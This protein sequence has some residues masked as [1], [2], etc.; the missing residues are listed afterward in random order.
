[1]CRPISLGT[2]GAI[3]LEHA[4]LGF[5]E[6]GPVS[7]YD[8]KTRCF[9]SDLAHCWTADQAQVYRTLDRMRARGLV[10]SR[11]AASKGGRGRPDRRLYTITDA[12]RAELAGW[13]SQA[14]APPPLRD[15]FLLQLFFA[16]ELPADR[17]LSLLR[18]ER[19]ARQSRLD[20]LRRRAEAV[21]SPDREDSDGER[22]PAFRKMTVAAAVAA[23]RTS[24]DWLD[25]CIE[26]VHAGIGEETG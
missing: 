18:E 14:A 24:I 21:T 15:P 23:A 4:I 12:G 6:R 2:G 13:L 16:A 11:S 8:L 1:M 26:A 25:D 22:A 20:W 3:S 5:L 19:A 10:T 9:D 17:V 7:G